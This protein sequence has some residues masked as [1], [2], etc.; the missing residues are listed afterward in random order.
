[1]SGLYVFFARKCAGKCMALTLHLLALMFAEYVAEHL[2]CCPLYFG[3]FAHCV[4]C[5]LGGNWWLV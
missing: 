3:V 5:L 1:M 2:R 4:S